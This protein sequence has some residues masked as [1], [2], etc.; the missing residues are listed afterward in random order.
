MHAAKNTR[1]STPQ[2]SLTWVFPSGWRRHW[3]PPPPIRED[4][5]TIFGRWRVAAQLG[6]K[7]A[8]AVL[9]AKL[10]R[11]RDNPTSSSGN[12]APVFDPDC[13]H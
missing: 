7:T 9:L 4:A 6:H 1:R 11:F 13:N 8:A 2:P 5:L 3:P 10:E 12:S